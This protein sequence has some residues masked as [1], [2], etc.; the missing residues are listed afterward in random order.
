MELSILYRG[1]GGVIQ[2]VKSRVIAVMQQLLA[3]GSI[4]DLVMCGCVFEK[5]TQRLFPIGAKQSADYGGL[6][7]CKKLYQKNMRL[8][9]V[10]GQKQ[11][12]SFLRELKLNGCVEVM[13]TTILSSLTCK[14]P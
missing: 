5:D 4:P 13:F 11:R 14:K 8:V 12:A 6:T 3:R 10:V 7:H 1:F 9:S 2:V